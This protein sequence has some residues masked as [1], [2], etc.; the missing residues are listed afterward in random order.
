MIFTK[1]QS[2]GINKQS[3]TNKLS[4]SYLPVL[5]IFIPS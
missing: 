2:E 1:K 5:N 4:N 3:D